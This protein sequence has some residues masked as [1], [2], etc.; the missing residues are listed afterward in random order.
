MLNKRQ[1][2]FRKQMADIQK[3]Q[4][5]LNRA[6]TY[7]YSHKKYDSEKKRVFYKRPA[8]QIGSAAGIV[9]LTWNIYALS[10]YLPPWHTAQPDTVETSQVIKQQNIHAYIQESGEAE[11]SLSRQLNE[12]MQQF[13]QGTLTNKTVTD[14]QKGL[15]ILQEVTQTSDIRLA[16]LQSY[17]DDQFSL[18]YQVTDALQLSDA[19]YIPIELQYVFIEIEKN[20]S[21]KQE[22]LAHIFESED[23][24]YKLHLDGSIS[25]EYQ[26]LR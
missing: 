7:S 9:I 18:A 4:P 25:Y 15:P 3:Q 5:Q 14:V 8:F 2:H 12:L 16:A 19:S 11:S 20:T 21:R 13:E 17:Y 23:I 26:S 22:V 10:T 6:D 24:P 1:R